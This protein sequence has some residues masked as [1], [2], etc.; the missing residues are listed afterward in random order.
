V[1]AFSDACLEI[2]G[3]STGSQWKIPRLQVASPLRGRQKKKNGNHVASGHVEGITSLHFTPISHKTYDYTKR[4][5]RKKGT[6]M[7]GC[8]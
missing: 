2:Y 5:K 4:K 8:E 3:L 6:K 7:G 1:P